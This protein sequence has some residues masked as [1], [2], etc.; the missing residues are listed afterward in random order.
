M[1]ESVVS[2]HPPDTA[3]ADWSCSIDVTQPEG[4]GHKTITCCPGCTCCIINN[5]LLNLYNRF[6]CAFAA[7][8]KHLVG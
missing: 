2:T 7:L 5:A 3:D 6:G 4:P 8:R 1:I